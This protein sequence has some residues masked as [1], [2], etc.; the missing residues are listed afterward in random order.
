MLKRIYEIT[1]TE[2]AC[3]FKIYSSGEATISSL[4][5]SLKKDFSHIS[6]CLKKLFSLGL[7]TRESK[8]CSHGKKGRYWVYKPLPKSKFKKVL[9]KRTNKIHKGILKSIRRL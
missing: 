3:I 6:R 2:I 7:I 9:R 1:D 4:A 8:C 5:K